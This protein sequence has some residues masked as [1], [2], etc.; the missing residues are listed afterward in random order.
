MFFRQIYDDGLAQAS[1]MVGSSGDGQALVVDP[2]RDVDVYLELAAQ[3]DLRIVAVAETHIH[4]DFLSGAP[5]L[6]HLTGATLHLSG[7]GGGPDGYAPS[8]PDSVRFLR[9]GE[10]FSIGNVRVRAR[11]T[12]GHTPEH[13]SFEIFDD[14]RKPEPMLL[15]SGDFMFV[16]DLGRPD[17]LERSLS[18][19]GSARAGAVQMFAS[20]RRALSELPDYVQVWPGH[21]AG[22]ACGRALGAVPSTTLGYERRFSW[23]SHLEETGDEPGFIEALLR[24]QPD[25]PSYFAEMKRLNRGSR[26]LLGGLPKPP[27]LDA[28]ALKRARADGAVLIDARAK[29]TFIRSHPEGAVSIPDDTSFSN[30][31]AW[32]VPLGKQIVLIAPPARVQELVRRL[33]RVGHDRIVGFVPDQTDAQLLLEPLPEVSAEHAYRMWSE[34][35]AVIVD[36]RSEVEYQGSRIPGALHVPSG[37]LLSALDRLP[38]DR[39]LIVHCAAGDRSVAAS[40]ALLANGFSRVF[41]L[42]RGLE[43]WRAEGLPLESES[44]PALS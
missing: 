12:P 20:L 44:V 6:A 41:N 31:A 19:A 38:R 2:R 17:L 14:P 34:Q 27:L 33:V 9:D 25:A 43:D 39:T 4:A 10:S 26:P 29:Q 3:K 23:W 1:Y 42:Q 37:R 21:G 7:E 5:E 30:W 8:S 32:F 15:L 24:D 36:V 22:S 13:V 18:A 35:E 11:H 16:G 40:S 28:S